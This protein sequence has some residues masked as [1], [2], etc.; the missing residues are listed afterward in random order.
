MQP[1]P[2]GTVELEVFALPPNTPSEVRNKAASRSKSPKYSTTVNELANDFDELMRLCPPVSAKER[3]KSTSR[4]RVN[5][6]ELTITGLCEAYALF[7]RELANSFPDMNDW[8][9]RASNVRRM[10]NRC[11]QQLSDDMKA[12]LAD[13]S[14][15]FDDDNATST[16]TVC[17]FTDVH[18]LLLRAVITWTPDRQRLKKALAEVQDICQ[19][20][21][22]MY[23]CERLLADIYSRAID[24]IETGAYQNAVQLVRVACTKKS[25]STDLRVQI[26]SS[27]NETRAKRTSSRTAKLYAQQL[28]SIRGLTQEHGQLMTVPHHRLAH[29]LCATF[30][31]A[32]AIESG[33]QRELANDWEVHTLIVGEVTANSSQFS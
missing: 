6:D 1:Q 4:E 24:L 11:A 18:L 3:Q 20:K 8:R 21:P 27:P 17:P 15:K 29:E 19:Q 33:R 30:Y 10:A 7:V 32:H 14:L 26:L 2:L 13:K 16:S 28:E 5:G 25:S 23:T 31:C 9:E 12:L 22:L